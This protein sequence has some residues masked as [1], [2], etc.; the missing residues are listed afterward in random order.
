MPTPLPLRLRALTAVASFAI[1]RGWLP[2]SASLVEKPH[3]ERL[4]RKALWF[5]CKLGDRSIRT[6]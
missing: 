3:D 4:A 1:K 6:T 5:A 2:N